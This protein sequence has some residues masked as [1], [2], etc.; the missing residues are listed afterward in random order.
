[1]LIEL[2]S[3]ATDP[4]NAPNKLFQNFKETLILKPNSKIALVSALT[5]TNKI[6]GFKIDVR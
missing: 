6:D 2:R 4:H 1:M 3:S 5:T